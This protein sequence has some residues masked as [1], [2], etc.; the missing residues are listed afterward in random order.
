MA[1]DTGYAPKSWDFDEEVARV[2]D[3]MLAR[4]IP[5]Y[6]VMRQ[7]CFDLACRYRQERTDLVDLGCS[8]GGAIENLT[9]KFGAHNRFVG[10]EVSEPMVKAARERFS[11]LINCGVVEVR[12]MDLRHDYPP[13]SASVTLCILT[14]QFTPI[15]Y[16]QQIVRSIYEHTIA[17]GAVIMV[18]KI[19]GSSAEMDKAFN[20][21]YWELK[22]KA[23]YS[24]DEIDRKRW[25]LEGKL[26]P[27]TARWNEELL[28]KAGFQD[29]ECFWRLFNF[30]G[31]LGVKRL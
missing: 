1:K 16:R 27:V 5:Q 13:V 6:D 3:D 2:F 30:A 29:V 28:T 18:E 20:E 12:Q 8:R 10:V 25:S 24:Q 15:E 26:V 9:K 7:A 19:L 23:G 31:W 14:L 11:G 4:S 21:E 22:K 17:G